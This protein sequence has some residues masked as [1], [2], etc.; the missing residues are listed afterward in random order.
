MEKGKELV[1][2]QQEW[3]P[4][5]EH[6]ETVLAK[7]RAEKLDWE[8]CMGTYVSDARDGAVYRLDYVTHPKENYIRLR[9]IRDGTMVEWRRFKQPGDVS[10]WIAYLELIASLGIE[11]DD[12]NDE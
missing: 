1:K 9:T 10:S 12:D 2:Q 3:T 5:D 7:V 8:P 4:P 6:I 11:D